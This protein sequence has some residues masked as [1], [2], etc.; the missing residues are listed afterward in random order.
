MNTRIVIADALGDTAASLA[1]YLTPRGFEVETVWDGRQAIDA[2]RKSNA[3]ALIT[4]LTLPQMTAESVAVALRQEFG[5][6]VRLIGFSDWP[7]ERYADLAVQG[8]FDEL[9]TKPVDEAAIFASLSLDNAIL[10]AALRAACRRR[11]QLMLDLHESMVRFF[12]QDRFDGPRKIRGVVA[13]AQQALQ[14]ARLDAE[15]R[16][17]AEERL[18]RIEALASELLESRRP[19]IDD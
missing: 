3:A 9:A 14:R 4:D 10:D 19:A 12:A 17:K 13:R 16:R 15:H 11:V 7:P 18:A 6:A 2:V 8:L 5:G 1:T